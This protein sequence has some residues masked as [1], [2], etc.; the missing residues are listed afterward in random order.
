L[1]FTVTISDSSGGA[2]ATS[3]TTN[4]ADAPLVASARTVRATEG[5]SF[6]GTVASFSDLN[7]EAP[8]NDFTARITWGDGHTS[9]GTVVSLGGG[10]FVV[11][12]RNTYAEEGTYAVGVHVQDVGGSSAAATGT[13]RVA[14]ARLHATGTTL[15]LTEGMA[16][17]G[18][19]ATFTD[20]NPQAD[21]HDLTATIV[22]GDGHTSTGTIVTAGGGFAV[23]GSN[24]YAEK[25]VYTMR[26]RINDAGGAMALATS[27]A[28]VRDAPLSGQA[29]TVNAA[30]GHPV[31]ATV[32]TFTDGNPGAGQSD[33]VATVIWGDG[34][35]SSG[36]V[37]LNPSS[38]FDVVGTHTYQHT[39]A[40]AITVTM[41]DKDGFRLTLKGKA[42][43]S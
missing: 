28:I 5:L 42:Q 16:F 3:A 21:I 43:V 1:T 11:R 15:R 2:T 41:V 12:G 30:L 40:F 14:D 20:A 6:S 10:Q 7:P 29:V 24:T 38:G 18:T 36:T 9:T 32:A 17:S 31:T 22:W 35:T 33:F 8:V 26:V 19:V 23:L 4:V 34:H 27:T 13:A 37:V 25:G 39:G